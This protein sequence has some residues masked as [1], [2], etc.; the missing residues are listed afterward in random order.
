MK[1]NL[2]DFRSK[3]DGSIDKDFVLYADEIDIDQSDDSKAVGP[4]A[5]RMNLVIAGDVLEITISV[6]VKF[7]FVCSRCLDSFFYDLS[8]SVEDKVLMSDLDEDISLDL[9]GNLDFTNYIRSCVVSNVPQKKLCRDGCLGLCQ[10]CGMDLNKGMCVCEHYECDS[11]FS[12][13][14]EVF[15]ELKEVE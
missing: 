1:I 2:R 4:L 10:R 15:V 5:V 6:S 8:F 14:R 12:R 3:T 11:P 7:Q 13:L 9:E